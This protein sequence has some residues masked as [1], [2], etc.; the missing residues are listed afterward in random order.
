M[1]DARLAAAPVTTD[2]ILYDFAKSITCGTIA[3]INPTAPFLKPEAIER[4]LAISS[5][6][7]AEATVFT[8]TLMRRHLVIDGVP[9][10][11]ESAGKSPRTQD[12]QPFDYI[13]F[14]AFTISRMKV[15]SHYERRG[16]CLHVPPL[17]FVPMAGLECHDIDDEDDFLI[18][19]AIMTKERRRAGPVGDAKS[20]TSRAS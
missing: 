17:A 3:V 10:N 2:E 16:Y 4:V 5:Q 11:F 13:N 1:R 12:L 18:A 9:K 15:L 7:G 8:V 20:R 6:K 19:E 14:I